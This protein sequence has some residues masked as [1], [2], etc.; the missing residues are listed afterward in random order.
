[1]SRLS[2][3]PGACL[4]LLLVASPGFPTPRA[5]ELKRDLAQAKSILAGEVT[6]VYSYYGPDGEI[7]SDVTLRVAGILKQSE[8]TADSITFTTAGG[9]VGDEGIAYSNSSFFSVNE[10][11]LVLLE[12]WVPGTLSPASKYEL[13]GRYLPEV[14]M[15]GDNLLKTIRDL[16]ADRG[17]TITDSEWSRLVEFEKAHRQAEEP[18]PFNP[19]NPLA[20]CYVITG[21]RWRSSN[22]QFR[23]DNALPA[24]MR[25][26]I[27]A[28]VSTINGMNLSLRF[29]SSAFGTNLISRGSI[30]SG[31]PSALAVARYR[32]IPSTQTMVDYT[33]TFN[34]GYSWASTGAGG[35]FDTEGVA[36]H[37]FGHIAGLNHPTPQICDQHT[38]WFSVGSGDTS[39]R[40]LEVGDTAGLQAIYG[41]VAAPPPPPS[42]PPPSAPPPSAPGSTPPVPT[43]DSL[44][45]AGRLVTNSTLTFSITGTN[46]TE[47][48]QFVV[49]GQGCPSTGCILSGGSVRNLTATSAVSSFVPRGTG[50][51]RINVRNTALGQQSA[52][53][54]G[55]TVF[56]R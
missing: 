6:R 7:Y 41:T 28:A 43:L 38:M 39:R 12:E 32:F 3:L 4:A 53:Q 1:M 37:E 22:V 21:P 29:Q 51:Y 14:Q 34:N 49:R 33:I 46:F 27:L 26:S 25:T 2:A 24:D 52:E 40:S 45:V 9:I 5:S 56:I 42:A 31:N 35:T 17:E 36:L 47:F 16:L 8:P 19:E 13:D 54:L 48:L 15:K 18:S 10:P 30:T 11:V 55:F 50:T 44:N 20:S 23:L